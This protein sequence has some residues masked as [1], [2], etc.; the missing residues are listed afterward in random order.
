MPGSLHYKPY[1]LKDLDARDQVG[2]IPSPKW[3]G[4]AYFSFTLLLFSN[5]FFLLLLFLMRFSIHLSKIQFKH[6]A[7]WESFLDLV[8]AVSFNQL[9]NYHAGGRGKGSR[10]R[11]CIESHPFLLLYRFQ[12][13]EEH[14][15]LETAIPSCGKCY[16]WRVLGLWEAHWALELVIEVREVCL[17]PRKR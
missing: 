16:E 10:P 12:C 13:G 4:K 6:P 7:L 2:S 9:W 11:W 3:T 5:L 14:T 1:L 17:V 8:L 15:W